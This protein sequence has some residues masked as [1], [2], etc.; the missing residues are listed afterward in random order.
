MYSLKQARST[1]C[2]SFEY[3]TDCYLIDKT[4]NI[5]RA[6]TEVLT[7]GN[8]SLQISTRLASSLYFTFHSNLANS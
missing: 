2:T 7:A 8:F 6:F 4:P 1:L 5:L 3:L